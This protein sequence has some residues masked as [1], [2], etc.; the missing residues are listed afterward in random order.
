[1]A[2]LGVS[3]SFWRASR[4]VEVPVMIGALG[5]LLLV[6]SVSGTEEVADL[7]PTERFRQLAD[8]ATPL[9]RDNLT[10]PAREPAPASQDR[11]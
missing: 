4:I 8:P 1:M 9:P 6:M 7:P 2:L 5:L 10:Q 3:Y 11:S